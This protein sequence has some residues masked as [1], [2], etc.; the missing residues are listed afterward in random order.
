V[1]AGP[2]RPVYPTP[3]STTRFQEFLQ[4]LCIARRTYPIAYD[5]WI[6]EQIEEILGLPELSREL[7]GMF[8]YRRFERDEL[9]AKPRTLERLLHQYVG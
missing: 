6:R 8:E 9:T 4:A 1:S 2:R 3:D 5:K 7:P